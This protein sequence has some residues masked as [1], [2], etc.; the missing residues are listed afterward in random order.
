MKRSG[1]ILKKNKGV[2]QRI[3]EQRNLYEENKNPDRVWINVRMEQV[4]GIE[5]V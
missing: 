3:N 2:L 5:P 1:G 4:A